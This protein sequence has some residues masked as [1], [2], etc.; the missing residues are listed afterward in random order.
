MYTYTQYT[1]Q[2]RVDPPSDKFNQN[3]SHEINLFGNYNKVG[4]TGPKNAKK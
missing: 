3:L 1:P 4:S 2:V